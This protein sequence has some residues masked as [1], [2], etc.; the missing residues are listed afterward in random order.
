MHGDQ[1]A[2]LV[3]VGPNSKFDTLKQGKASGRAV[4]QGRMRGHVPKRDRSDAWFYVISVKCAGLAVLSP[5]VVAGTWRGTVSLGDDGTMMSFTLHVDNT[6][7]G[8]KRPP[9]RISDW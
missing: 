2:R 7:N 8:F 4:P 3:S 9:G 6:S 1:S 5:A